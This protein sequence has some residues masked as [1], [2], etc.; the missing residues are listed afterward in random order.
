MASLQATHLSVTFIYVKFNEL[1]A[2]VAR[3][4]AKVA[5]LELENAKLRRGGTQTQAAFSFGGAL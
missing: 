1:Q 2:K 4:E 3:L 5:E